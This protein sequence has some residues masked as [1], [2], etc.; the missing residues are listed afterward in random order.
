M[1]DVSEH[2]DEDDVSTING[3]G[4]VDSGNAAQLLAYNINRQEK[5][6]AARGLKYSEMGQNGYFRV[7]GYDEDD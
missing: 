4:M 1:D 2:S 3:T 6:R 7:L 5:L